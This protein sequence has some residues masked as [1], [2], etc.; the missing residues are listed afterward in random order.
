LEQVN[1]PEAQRVR[2]EADAFH[3]SL[4]ANFH[5][6]ADRSPVVRLRDGTSVRK[7]PSYVH[8][9]GRSF[10]WICETL[11]GAMH[12][13]I[14]GA[15][16]P[17]SQ[18]AL[19][20]IKDYEDNLYLSNQYG[21][22]LDDFDK[23]WFGRGGMSMQACLLLDVEPYLYRD[24]V[25]HA[26]RGLFNALAVSHFPDVHM[27]TEHAL[28]EMGDWRGD[29]YKSSDESNACGWLRYLFVREEGNDLLL[30]QGVPRVW[31]KPGQ[32]CGI[33]RAAT[34]FGPVSVLYAPQVSEIT[35]QV[36]GPKRNAPQHIR[37]RF[38]SPT[39]HPI[40][41]VTV[42]GEA[43]KRFSQ[44]WVDLPGNIGKAEVTARFVP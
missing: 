27:N 12:L 36:D 13:L 16:D 25:K 29:H 31:L 8:R 10:G 42:N 34:Y 3:A 17:H 1:H 15:I 40:S 23:E 4:L 20:I 37:L 7:I 22:T 33:E 32:R 41:S 9:R 26:L 2:K 18:E 39:E 43:W 14:T 35:A 24:D 44:D 6:A 30:G 5:K 19:W 38:R 11:E 28:P 21:Y